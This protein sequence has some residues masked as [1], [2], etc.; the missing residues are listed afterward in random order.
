MSEPL[1]VAVLVGSLRAGS[2]SRKIAR[3]L[4]ERAPSG[5]V[6]EFVEIGELP[7]YNEDLD[8]GEPPA[9][10]S[11]FRASMELANAVLFVTPEYN[12]S[13]PGCLKNALDVGSR[14]PKRSVFAGRPAAVVS[15]TPYQLGAFGANHALR[16]TFVFLDMPALQQPELYV[17]RVRDVVD[18]AGA[19]KDPQSSALFT[20]FMSAF[21]HFAEAN[22]KRTTAPDFEAFMRKRAAPGDGTRVEVLHREASGE[23]GFWTGVEHAKVAFDGAVTPMGMKLRVTEIFRF[24]NGD[25]RLVHR[26]ADAAGDEARKSAP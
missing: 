20:K 25:F 5:M 19:V 8:E 10:W 7:L 13:V 18:D 1:R 11:R 4:S 23:L 9:A 16:Q 3:A 14:P 15:V 26:H 17:G 21:A 24:E 6:C 22:R 2:Y 12:R